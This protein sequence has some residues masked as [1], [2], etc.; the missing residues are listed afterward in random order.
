MRDMPAFLK[1]CARICLRYA[2]ICRST[3][4][5]CQPL[6]MTTYEGNF[7]GNFLS[8]NICRNILVCFARL[9]PGEIFRILMLGNLIKSI[10]CLFCMNATEEVH[11]F[12]GSFQLRRK[13]G[14]MCLNYQFLSFW[15]QNPLELAAMQMWAESNAGLSS[16]SSISEQCKM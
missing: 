10:C 9:E 11:R 13:G 3:G 14:R 15:L 5:K 2:K 12:Y 7:F 1:I 6:D 8:W 4:S 16:V